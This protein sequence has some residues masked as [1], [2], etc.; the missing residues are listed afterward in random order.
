MD[1]NLFD[2]L[3]AS[4]KEAGAIKRNEIKASRVTALELPDIKEVREKTGLTQAEFAARLHI[5]ARTLQNWE[6]GCRYPTGPA[7]TLIRI[8]DAHPTLI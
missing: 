7:A 8:L 5:S 2:D 3:V 6:Q 4:I 1:N